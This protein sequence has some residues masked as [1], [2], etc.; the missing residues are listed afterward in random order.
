MILNDTFTNERVE[1]T[2]SR[3]FSAQRTH[4]HAE[5]IMSDALPSQ[6]S[7]IQRPPQRSTLHAFWNLPAPPVQPP[8]FHTPQQ[9]LASAARCEDCDAALQ[10]EANGME[11]DMEIDGPMESSPFACNDCGRAVCGT[12]A[13]VSSRRH[14]LG[15]ATSGNSRR[16]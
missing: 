8:T 12:C 10:Q 1:T 16:W 11:V 13:V 2:I 14:C 4:P 6:P 7:T 5:P 3:L 9:Q 15:C